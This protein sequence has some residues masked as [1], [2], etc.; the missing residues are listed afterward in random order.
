MTAID[1]R[2]QLARIDLALADIAMRQEQLK[3]LKTYEG[4]RLAFQ[5]L[6]AGGAVF[7]AGAA[8]MAIL[9]HVG[10]HG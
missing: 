6:T 3:Q 5:G 4:W 7:A 9:L 8:V 1:E 2:E 10:A